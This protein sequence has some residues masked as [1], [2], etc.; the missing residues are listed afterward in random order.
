MAGPGIRASHF[1]R[2]LASH[3][4]VTLIGV[5]TDAVPIER[6]RTVDWGSGDARLAMSEAQVI[7]AQPHRSILAMSGERS[8]KVYDLFD[9]VI[10]ELDQ[11]Y[12]GSASV[13][14]R[15]HRRFEQLRLDRALA[16]GDLLLAATQRQV[17]FYTGFRR[18]AGAV[19]EEWM[20]RWRVV[21]FG[22]EDLRDPLV[23]RENVILWGGGTWDW[24]DPD[25]AVEAVDRLNASGTACTLQF[26]GQQRPNSAARAAESISIRQ[27]PFVRWNDDWVPYQERARWLQRSKV[28][29]MLHR[30]TVEAEYSIRT[31]LFDAIGAGL[32][33]VATAGGFAAELVERESLGVV[34]NPSDLDSVVEGTRRL[35]EDDAF[36]SASVHNM[37]RIRPEFDWAAVTRPLVDAIQN[38]ER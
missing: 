25:L 24:L 17:D 11:L 13:R 15:M 28:A 12:R 19:D 32:P 37:E 9:P 21:P 22:A 23:A 10:L 8:K 29:M 5:I 16:D 18:A 6:V 14:Q 7:V 26:L 31:R 20:R 4:E 35:L 36:H 3:F 1:A 38:W 34:V 30:R 2:E 27:S 33:V